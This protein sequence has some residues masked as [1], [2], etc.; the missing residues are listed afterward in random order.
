MRAGKLPS[1]ATAADLLALPEGVRVELV[2][3]EIMYKAEPTFEHADA[4]AGVVTALRTRFHGASVGWWIVTECDV[5]YQGGELYRH[6]VVGWRRERLPSRPASRPVEVRPDWVCEILS[7][8]NART[9]Q[10]DKFVVLR[11]QGVPHYWI[12]DPEQE[13]LAV[14]RWHADGYLEVL[15]VAAERGQRVRAEPF[16]AIE[17]PVGAL[18]GHDEDD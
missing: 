14:Y 2:H 18:F 17:L 7:A 11:K 4:Q 10:V 16:D 8:S 15:A 9:D 13:T 3:G 6:D 12:V 1:P 5:L